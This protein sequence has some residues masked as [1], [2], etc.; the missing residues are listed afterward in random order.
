MMLERIGQHGIARHYGIHSEMDSRRGR[1]AG[2]IGDWQ[3][4]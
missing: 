4:C 2:S 3:R 1:H